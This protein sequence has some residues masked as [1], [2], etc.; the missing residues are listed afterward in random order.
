MDGFLEK[1]NSHQDRPKG[2]NPRPH[3]IGSANWD[4]LG[5]FI[6]QDHTNGEANKEAKHPPKA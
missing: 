2:A 4:V 5:G 6:E 1:E 3:C